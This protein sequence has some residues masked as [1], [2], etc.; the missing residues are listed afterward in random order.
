MDTR[1]LQLAQ[2]VVDYSLKL[3]SQDTL[4]LSYEPCFSEFTDLIAKEAEKKQA[5]ILHQHF[6]LPKMKEL[7]MEGSWSDWQKDLE[8]QVQL[9]EEATAYARLEASSNLDYLSGVPADRLKDYTKMVTKPVRDIKIQNHKKRV[10]VAWPCSVYAQIAGM[11]LEEYREFI[12]RTSLID[13]PLLRKEMEK[14]KEVFDGAKDVHIIVPGK[15]NLHLSLEDRG[16]CIGAAT[17]NMPCGE[18]FYGPV[19]NSLEGF[20]SF[21]YPADFRGKLMGGIRL[22]FEKGDVVHFSAESNEVALA[23]LLE[24]EGAQR[25]GE[26]GIGCNPKIKQPTNLLL[27]DEKMAGTIHLALGFSYPS[28]LSSGGGHHKSIV[29]VDMVCELRK[30]NGQPGGKIYVDDNLVQEDGKW[31][32]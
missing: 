7:I 30:I 27:F 17:Q 5:R 16:A 22:E 8:E 13:W 31:C 26:F 3:N 28:S 12:F 21:A 25:A 6:D 20:I 11:S 18:I 19:E 14:V 32:F 1:A 23:E 4:L 29:H 24:Q 10:L 9:V 15:T 2:L